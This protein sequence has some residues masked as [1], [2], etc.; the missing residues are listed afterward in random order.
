M[1]ANDLYRIGHMI[2]FCEKILG[3]SE[4]VIAG[5]PI[6]E[7]EQLGLLRLFETLG[8]AASRVS[9]ELEECAP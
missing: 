4:E 3:F 9:N 1:P 8:E 7:M 2:S 6:S 5:R